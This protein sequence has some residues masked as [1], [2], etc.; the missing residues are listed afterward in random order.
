MNKLIIAFSILL[1]F[2]VSTTT[3]PDHLTFLSDQIDVFT[4]T[5]SDDLPAIR[6][7]WMDKESYSVYNLNGLKRITGEDSKLEQDGWTVYYSF[8]ENLVTKTCG[9]KP[10]QWG[11]FKDSECH[12]LAGPIG[13]GNKWSLID[14]NPDKGVKIV[15]NSGDK[16]G[17]GDKT[18]SLTLNMVCDPGIVDKP[19]IT[20]VLNPTSCDNEL[21]FE[22]SQACP[23][24]DLYGILKFIKQNSPLFGIVLIV[25]GVFLTFFGNKLITITI[26]LTTTIVCITLLFVFLVGFVVFG[27]ANL[28]IVLAFAIFLGLVFGY[29]V[30]K[31][32]KTL[33]GFTLGAYLGYLVGILLYDAL[34]VRI[35]WHLGVNLF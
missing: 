31:F 15:M 16:C 12:N 29:M 6:C 4:L 20:G 11:A 8:C 27:G 7:F 24:K 2:T 32:K 18:Y 26:F 14:D 17:N 33:I 5:D 22:T 19:I 1:A 28:W 21:F 13:V 10:G 3:L 25:A 9:D 34:L 23:N 35:A 30:A